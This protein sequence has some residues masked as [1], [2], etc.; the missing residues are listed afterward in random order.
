VQQFPSNLV[1]N[2]GG[3]TAAKFFELDNAADRNA[4]KVSFS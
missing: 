3:F 2:M 4:P 1:A